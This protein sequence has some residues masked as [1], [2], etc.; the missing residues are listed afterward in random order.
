MGKPFILTGLAISII[1]AFKKRNWLIIPLLFILMHLVLIN[2]FLFNIGAT[3][4][5]RLVYH[6][7]L[8]CVFLLVY[9]LYYLFNIFSKQILI[10]SLCF[11]CL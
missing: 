3:M 1:V 9:G 2:N 5:E 11:I 6:S 4:G 7:H 10:Y 8:E